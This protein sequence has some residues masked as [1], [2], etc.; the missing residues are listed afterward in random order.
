M[1]GAAALHEGGLLLRRYAGRADPRGLM[2]S[3][4][5]LA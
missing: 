2:R 3:M 5:P 1:I 4:V